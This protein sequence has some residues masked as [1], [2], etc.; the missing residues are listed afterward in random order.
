MPYVP[1]GF[2]VRTS[3]FGAERH[4][5]TRLAAGADFAAAPSPRRGTFY[6]LY[7]FSL[8]RC[9]HERDVV[10]GSFD[11][12]AVLVITLFTAQDAPRWGLFVLVGDVFIGAA[13]QHM[14][15]RF[16]EAS[17]HEVLIIVELVFVKFDDDF[18]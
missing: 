8:P 5:T 16:V 11:Y 13:S 7:E 15:E 1:A 2:R 18:E 9:S 10:V 3:R 12:H 14:V 6:T 17:F 4:I